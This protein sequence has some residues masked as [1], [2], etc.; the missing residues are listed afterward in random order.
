MRAEESKTT[1]RRIEITPGLQVFICHS[2]GAKERVRSLYSRLKADGFVP[3]LDEE[4]I[5]PAQH[6]DSEIRQAVR[7][8]GIVAVCLSKSSVMKEGYVQKETSLLLMLRS[9]MAQFF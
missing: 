8:S 1:P 3:W 6:W 2:S 9:P 4:D 5:L 7:T